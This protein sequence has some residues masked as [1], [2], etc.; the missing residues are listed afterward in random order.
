M[1]TFTE[2][3]SDDE[4]NRWANVALEW[5]SDENRKFGD[6]LK[7]L[8]TFLILGNA[9]GFLA[10]VQLIDK[11]KFETS[12]KFSVCAFAT[13]MVLG[14]LGGLLVVGSQWKCL[15]DYRKKIIEFYKGKITIEEYS[16]APNYY[17][18]PIGIFQ[19]GAV[20]AFCLGGASFGLWLISLS[21]G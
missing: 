20:F 16:H 18:I 13:G 3:I 7:Q 15:N 17:K 12:L 21:T 1:S 10:I 14:I 6:S 19:L 4:K 2:D 11:S 5:L 8:M 9:A